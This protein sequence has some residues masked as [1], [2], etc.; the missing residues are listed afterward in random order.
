MA[1]LNLD[2]EALLAMESG[3]RP[4]HPLVCGKDSIQKRLDYRIRLLDRAF[5]EDDSDTLCGSDDQNSDTGSDGET[6]GSG[7]D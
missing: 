3:G 7:S 4:T 6:G 1:T 2:D 5:E